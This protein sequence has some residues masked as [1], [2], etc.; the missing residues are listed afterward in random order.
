MGHVVTL[1]FWGKSRKKVSTK[2][3]HMIVRDVCEMNEGKI[4]LYMLYIYILLH[5]LRESHIQ[6][7]ACDCLPLP[8]AHRTTKLV[9]FDCEISYEHDLSFRVHEPCVEFQR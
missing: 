3:K 2:Q 8:I 7:S 6:S 9:E 4:N 5:K 1:I